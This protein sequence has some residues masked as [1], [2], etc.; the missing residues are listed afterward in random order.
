MM[1]LLPIVFSI[2]I[3]YLEDFFVLQM[4][5]ICTDFVELSMAHL[6]RQN[7]RFYHLSTPRYARNAFCVM[8]I[9]FVKFIITFSCLYLYYYKGR[10]Y[11]IIYHLKVRHEY[12]KLIQKNNIQTLFCVS[13]LTKFVASQDLRN[14][15]Q[16]K[17]YSYKGIAIRVQQ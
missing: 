1:L 15:L 12:S 5:Y 2:I 10:C 3:K 6:L 9:D 7:S 11:A 4:R 17:R 14:T 13:I 16:L 8:L